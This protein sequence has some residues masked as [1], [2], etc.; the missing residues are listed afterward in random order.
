MTATPPPIEIS[1]INLRINVV[2]KT[3][4]KKGNKQQE[5]D[6]SAENLNDLHPHK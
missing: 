4:N 6:N 1:K 2:C 3:S 5:N